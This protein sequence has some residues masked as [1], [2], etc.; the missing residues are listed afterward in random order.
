M[1]IEVAR[2]EGPEERFCSMLRKGPE[3][4]WVFFSLNIQSLPNERGETPVHV[5]FGL[6]WALSI[7]TKPR[8]KKK[9]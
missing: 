1:I 3:G 8:L 5:L 6:L 4:Q 9:S 7:H 2:G